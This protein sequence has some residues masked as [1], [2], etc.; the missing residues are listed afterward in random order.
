MQMN[1]CLYMVFLNRFLLNKYNKSSLLYLNRQTHVI[2]SINVIKSLDKK[3][4]FDRINLILL[5][6]HVTVKK[7][8]FILLLAYI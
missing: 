1:S 2:Q 7:K 8:E 3:N 6:N 5:R 4:Q